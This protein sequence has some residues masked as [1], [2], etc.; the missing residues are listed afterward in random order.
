MKGKGVQPSARTTRATRHKE[1]PVTQVKKE[2]HSTEAGTDP[3]PNSRQSAMKRKSKPDA[4]MKPKK[5]QKVKK[6]DPVAK[7]MV[8]LAPVSPTAYT[9]PFPKHMRPSPEECRVLLYCSISQNF[10]NAFTSLLACI[11]CILP[12]FCILSLLRDTAISLVPLSQYTQS[13][14][15]AMTCRQLEMGWQDCMGSHSMQSRSNRILMQGLT[16]CT[17]TASSK[18]WTPW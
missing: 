3:M 15:Q 14:G 18:C 5:R 7:Q 8:K 11:W 12:A 6:E 17:H 16:A 2:E 10:Q 4:D 13:H 9:G 1:P